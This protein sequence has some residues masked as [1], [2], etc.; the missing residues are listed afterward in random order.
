[1]SSI[2]NVSFCLLTNTPLHNLTPIQNP[3]P[4]QS[5]IIQHGRC[6]SCP[7]HNRPPQPGNPIFRCAFNQARGDEEEHLVPS[8]W[9]ECNIHLPLKFVSAANQSASLSPD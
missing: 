6:S 2:A 5:F 9:S 8:A 1:M 3:P 7:T 4:Q